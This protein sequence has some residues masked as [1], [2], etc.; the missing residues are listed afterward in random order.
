M[1]TRWRSYDVRLDR[2]GPFHVRHDR[3]DG[4]KAVTWELPDGTSGIGEHRLADLVYVASDDAVWV[5]FAVLPED[6]DRTI[7][8]TEGEKAADAVHAA[9]YM[10]IATVCGAS[11]VPGEA[12]ANWLTGRR[13]ILWPDADEVGRRHM[14]RFGELLERTG[15]GALHVIRWPE[16]PAHGDAADTDMDTIER[17]VSGALEAGSLTAIRDWTPDDV[18]DPAMHSGGGDAPTARMNIPTA[19]ELFAK[20]PVETSWRWFGY[21]ADGTIGEIDGRAKAA[22]KSTLVAHLIRAVLDGT[23]FLGRATRQGPV[24]LLSEQ[25]LASLRSTLAP[26]GLIDRDDLRIL[27]WG[28]AIGVPW[29]EVVQAAVDTCTEVG[30]GLLVVDTLPQWAGLRGDSENDAGAALQALE[31]LQRAAG[32]GLTILVIRHDRKGSGEVGESARGS[33]AFGGV[34]DTILHLRRGTP[35]E[36]PTVRY[37]TALSRFPETPTDLV[38]ELTDEGYV[39]IG[40]ADGY[41]ESEAKQKIL[42]A[43]GEEELRRAEVEQATG[44]SGERLTAALNELVRGGWLEKSGRGVKGDPQRF[45]RGVSI[46][47][48]VPI[49]YGGNARRNESD[50]DRAK[51]VGARMGEVFAGQPPDPG[52]VD[53]VEPEPEPAEVAA[54]FADVEVGPWTN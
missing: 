47:S 2:D 43:I 48:G 42:A 22:G 33:T 45:R 21:L 14:G 36:R 39:P 4:S 31:P 12:V 29:D 30:A 16:A 27:V 9:G 1:T 37:L 11:S 46:H 6:L 52:V 32:D 40:D 10:A 8:I 7:V 18:S 35:E 13:V 3:A 44:I 53:D 54:L 17:L 34:V 28:E 51:S 5:D 20:V 41:A 25:P 23:P 19:R 49:P 24:V 38:I 50:P 15:V 26:V